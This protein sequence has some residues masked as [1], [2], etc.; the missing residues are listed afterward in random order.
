MKRLKELRLEKGVSQTELAKILQTTNKSIW[1]YESGYAIPP[2]EVLIK[3]A[4]Y[5]KCSIDYLVNR[6]NDYGIINVADNL[7]KQEEELITL[8]KNLSDSDK[9]KVIGYTQALNLK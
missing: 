6:E 5:F 8:F 9:N 1:A 3:I 4:D 2:L 7:S